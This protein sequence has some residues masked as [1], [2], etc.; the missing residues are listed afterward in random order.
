MSIVAFVLLVVAV[1]ARV[2]VLPS[3]ALLLSFSAT[4]CLY[5]IVS[6]AGVVLCG[7]AMKRCRLALSANVVLALVWA[8][9]FFGTLT[10]PVQR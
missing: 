3:R 10:F 5:C 1:R 8:A 6:A 9:I 4:L 7:R 2:L